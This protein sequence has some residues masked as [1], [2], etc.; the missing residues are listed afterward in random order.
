[1]PRL[2]GFPYDDKQFDRLFNKY[3]E[4]VGAGVY[5][6][7]DISH[8]CSVIGVSLDELVETVK[9][10]NTPKALVKSIKKLITWIQGQYMVAPGWGGPNASKAIFALKQ[11]LGGYTYTDKQDIKASGEM[12]VKIQ[13]G[14]KSTDF[15]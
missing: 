12:Q 15:D 13:F 9:G 4:D 1:M 2:P 14:G 6:R 7:A 11:D 5:A 3:K 8:F 10:E